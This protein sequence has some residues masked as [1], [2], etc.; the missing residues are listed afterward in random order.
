MR[1]AQAYFSPPAWFGVADLNA[2]RFFASKIFLITIIMDGREKAT[3]SHICKEDA[4]LETDA[5]V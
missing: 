4:K 5:D 2:S 1:K 3:H